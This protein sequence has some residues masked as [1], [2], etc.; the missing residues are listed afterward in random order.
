MNEHVIE[1]Y[2]QMLENVD[3]MVNLKDWIY[4]IDKLEEEKHAGRIEIAKFRQ[5]NVR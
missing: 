5:Q 1:Y 4:I 3:S 2:R